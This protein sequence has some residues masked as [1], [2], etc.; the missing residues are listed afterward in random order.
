MTGIT[1]VEV[2]QRDYLTPGADRSMTVG[3]TGAVIDLV[4]DAVVISHVMTTACRMRRMAVKV[5][6]MTC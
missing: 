2:M 6:G 5:G 3:T 1:A 4:K